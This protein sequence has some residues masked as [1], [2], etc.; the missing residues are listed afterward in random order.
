M[1]GTGPGPHLST[2]TRDDPRYSPSFADLP[3]RTSVSRMFTAV[4]I[5]A[6][7]SC[8]TPAPTSRD[9][10]GVQRGVHWASVRSAAR[11]VCQDEVK[12]CP[13]RVCVTG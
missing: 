13:V 1:A 6:S 2:L 7:G 5:H 8:G 11:G 3:P 9:Q 4:V 12:T 10:P